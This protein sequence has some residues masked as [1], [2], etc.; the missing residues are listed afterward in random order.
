MQ[1]PMIDWLSVTIDIKGYPTK[2][3]R[4]QKW[5]DSLGQFIETTE[6]PQM[7]LL[8]D[9]LDELKQ[10][11]ITYRSEY[12][13]E[14]VCIDIGGM[15]FEVKANG[16]NGYAYILHNHLLE[17]R[18]AKYRSP[19]ENN[20]PIF[21][22]LKADL[23]WEKGPQQAWTWLTTWI[24]NNFGEITADKL[25]R[26]DL[27]CHTDKIALNTEHIERFKGRYTT[28]TIHMAGK[29]CT[30]F[31]FGSRKTGTIKA[32]IYNK[33]KEVIEKK[34]KLWF[35]DIWAKNNLNPNNVWNIEFELHRTFFKE[36]EIESC[37]ELF[38]NLKPIWKYLTCNWLV[39]IDLTDP[40]PDRCQ[41]NQEWKELQESFNR[42]Q[43]KGQI[44]RKK[45]ADCQIE[46]L[47]ASGMGYISS[48]SALTGLINP[49]EA[50]KSLLD[51]GLQKLRRRGKDFSSIVKTKAGLF[52]GQ[53]A[54]GCHI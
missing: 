28:Y 11:A 25:N 20:Y 26:V 23:L 4:N 14:K 45:Q 29:E 40:R 8:I 31:E 12:N 54:I 49:E 35:F 39:M 17:I 53:R 37:Q 21:I 16:S 43:G 38:K 36:I 46:T 42:F 30:G 44:T 27:C 22:H 19:N 2:E 6:N 10:Q 48:Y 7:L 47:I 5:N 24:K 34:T 41:T 1:I 50:V 9:Q 18:I 15:K 32:R 13:Q 51:Y 33:T 3:S 52:V